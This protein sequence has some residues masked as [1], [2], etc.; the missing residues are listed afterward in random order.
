M[1][2]CFVLVSISDV[3][4][5][6]TGRSQSRSL[7][8]TLALADVSRKIDRQWLLYVDSPEVDLSGFPAMI[9]MEL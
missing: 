2:E 4:Q 6:L 8:A 9:Y 3:V 7:E 1:N 5:P